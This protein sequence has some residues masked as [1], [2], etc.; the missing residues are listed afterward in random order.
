MLKIT[1]PDGYSVFCAFGTRVEDARDFGQERLAAVKVNNETRPLS[2]RLEVNSFVEP[3]PLDSREGVTIYRRSLS[4]LLALAARE[5]FPDRGLCIGHSLGNSYYYTFEDGKASSRGEITAL[6]ARMEA[7][8]QEDLPIIFNYKAYSEAI[9]IFTR[10]K[11]TDTRRLLND[12]CDSKIQVN[13]CKD[14]TDLYM[15]PLAPRTGLL[16]T[17]DLM[18]YQDGFLLRFPHFKDKDKLGAFEDSPVVFSVYREYKKWGRIVGVDSVGRLNSLVAEGAARDYIGVAEAFQ[19]KKLAEIADRIYERL[20]T[21]KAVF[22]AGP[23]SSGKTTAAKRLA[24]QLKVMGVEPIPISLDNYY[25]NGDKT[26]RDENGQPDY[27]SLDALDVRYLNEQL[28]AFFRGGKVLVPL[29]DFKTGRRRDG[30]VPI[31]MNEKSILVVEGIHGLNDA[32]TPLIDKSLKFKLYVSALTQLNL[33]GHN[34]VPTSDNRL[35]RR[36]VRDRQFR[37]TSAEKTIR[38]WASVQNG[39]RKHIFPFQN[40]ADAVFNSSLDYELAVLK[41]YA[42]PILH[43]VKPDQTEYSEAARLLSF[44]ANFTPIPPQY[45]PGQSILREFIGESEFKY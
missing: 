6:K 17:F 4:F 26:P 9:E 13:E 21:V 36:L 43:S 45:T 23:S 32:L 11:Q 35:I 28:A 44:L 10:N 31:Q 15:G 24:I 39:E 33:D 20:G 25:L 12:Q 38:M 8:V 37:G 40:T 14:W 18:L 22:I 29:Y 42:E 34:R 5:L 1:F 41:F 19:A 3:V 27:E 30:G 16:K 7:L 2:F